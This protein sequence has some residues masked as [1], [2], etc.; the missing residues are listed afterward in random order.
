MAATDVSA[1]THEVPEPPLSKWFTSWRFSVATL[2]VFGLLAVFCYG[3]ARD[4]LLRSEGA[5]F[6]VEPAIVEFS[7]PEGADPGEISVSLRSISNHR[8]RIVGASTSCTCLVPGNQFPLELGIGERR[9]IVFQVRVPASKRDGGTVGVARF[10][11]E[12]KSPP[13]VVE[14]RL[15][16]DTNSAAASR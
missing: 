4:M 16:K 3:F 6:V 7:M 2:A 10:F 8:I 1:D 13:V 5:L 9:D 12:E 11:V 14:F 15:A